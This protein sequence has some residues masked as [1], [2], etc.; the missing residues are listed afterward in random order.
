M[1]GFGP[2]SRKNA[3]NAVW[4]FFALFML[5]LR[6]NSRFFLRPARSTRR[7]QKFS[8]DPR[9]R[10]P[11]RKPGLKSNDSDSRKTLD[12]VG[13]NYERVAGYL[14]RSGVA[15]PRLS[16]LFSGSRGPAYG[17]GEYLLYRNHA[18]DFEPDL[19]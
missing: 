4:I 17:R 18:H 10:N 15:F 13:Y 16:A 8:L 1:Y 12:T 7:V 2:F 9:L 14:A 3:K 11:G 5:T 6:K 19:F